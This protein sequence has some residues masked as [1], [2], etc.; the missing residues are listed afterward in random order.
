MENIKNKILEHYR[1]EKELKDATESF[2]NNLLNTP[3]FH[4]LFC[5]SFCC[6]LYCII[7]MQVIIIFCYNKKISVYF[8]CT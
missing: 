5:C 6:S 7:V 1:V 2:V 8:W 3:D 4:Y